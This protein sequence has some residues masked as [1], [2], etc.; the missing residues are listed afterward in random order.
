M[1]RAARRGR[2]VSLIGALMGSEEGVYLKLRLR[3]VQAELALHT[4]Y[5]HRLPFG[6]LHVDDWDTVLTIMGKS[7]WA[8]P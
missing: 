7:S 5:P 3:L 2:R 6:V 8:S 1:K 4:G